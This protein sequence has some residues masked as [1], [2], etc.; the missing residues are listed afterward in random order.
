MVCASITAN[1]E[2]VIWEATGTLTTVET[3][4]GFITD[5]P[6]ASIG[7]EFSV[8]LEYDASTPVTSINS[9]TDFGG[10]RWIGDRYRYDTALISINLS[11][12]GVPLMRA[13]DGFNLLD[14]W[15]NFGLAGVAQTTNECFEPGVACDGIATSQGLASSVDEGFASIALVLR[16]PELLNIY[17]GIGLPTEPSPALLS[18]SETFFQIIDQTDA[19]VGQ[20]ETLSRFITPEERLE[21]LLNEVVDIGPGGSLADKVEQAQAY[22][23]VPD[24]ESAC[25][26]LKAFIKQVSAQ[27]GK[28]LAAEQGV[29]LITRTQIILDAI[30]CD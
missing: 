25:G 7:S 10:T 15:D 23:A 12:D 17:S 22:L 24:I 4:G 30:G 26:I 16:G 5:F 9:S 11:I 20:V 1:A 19:I 27:T 2:V 29:D 28:K 6:T 21:E 14:I 18:L 3:S 8:L 13:P